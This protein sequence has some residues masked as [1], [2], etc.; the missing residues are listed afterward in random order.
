MRLTK[1]RLLGF[2]LA[3]SLLLGAMVG[4][5]R[6]DS[7]QDR[8]FE[9]IRFIY[10]LV[11]T[12][13][14]DGA[15]LDRFVNGA[16]RGGLEALG[17]P[18]TQYFTPEEYKAFIDGLNGEFSG[19]G[20]HLDQEGQYIIIAAPIK[21]SPAE[22]AGLQTGDRI[23]EANGTPLVGVPVEKAVQ[24]IRGPAGTTVTLKLERPS[25]SRTFTVTIT[26]A[27]INIPLVESKMLDAEVGYIQISSFGEEAAGEFFRAVDGLKKQ[28]AKA[29]VLDL[30]QNPGGFLDA[31]VEIAG[32]FIPKGEPVVWEVGKN[33][34]KTA[35]RSQGRLINLPT[36]VLIDEGSAS[37]SEVLAG[38][39]QDYGVA[40]LVGVKSFGKG[41]VQQLLRLSD[42]SGLKVTV[43]EYL[44]PKERHVHKV[45]LTPDL[46][47]EQPKPS[48]ERTQPLELERVLTVG[49]VGLD[50]LY[51]QY[52]LQD[53]GYDPDLHGFFGIKTQDAV[54]KFQ[55]DNWLK[56]QPVVDDAF[57]KVLNEKV[58]A[59]YKKVK[60]EDA[61]LKKAIEVVRQQIKP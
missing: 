25:E 41:T 61:Q 15:D 14:K 17:D 43:A 33:G 59:H 34:K 31:A 9:R 30:R 40:K 24:L 50:V 57:V 44:T 42:D 4:A 60:P 29:L 48:P 35:L 7:A 49:T 22:K 28:G 3:L 21:G 5:A 10:E 58:A 47:V 16:I 45:G 54:R 11:Q 18:Y 26:R 6:A 12:W 51:L 20:A 2:L 39:L 36:A 19:I 55:V 37:A 38:A 23:L 53:L 52:R 8:L 1:R 27:V 13:H 46:V 32:G 56:E